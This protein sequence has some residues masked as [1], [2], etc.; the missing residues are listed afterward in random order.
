M[1]KE[2]NCFDKSGAVWISTLY[3]SSED[4]TALY[5]YST[6]KGFKSVQSGSPVE[7]YSVPGGGSH[8]VGGNSDPG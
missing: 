2:F 8:L 5:Y 1:T 7:P 3:D 4:L 6:S